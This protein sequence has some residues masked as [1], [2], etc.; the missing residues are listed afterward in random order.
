MTEFSREE[1]MRY[2][3]QMILPGFGKKKQ[4]LLKNARV[5]VVGAGGLGCP[6]LSYLGA[7]GVGT[8]GITDFDKIE[9]SNLHR[10]FLFGHEDVGKQKSTVATQKISAQ[11]Q[12]ITVI[13]HPFMLTDS[14]AESVIDEYDIVVDGSDNFLTRYMVNDTCLKLNKVLIYGS[15]LRGEGQVAVFN[16]RGSKNLRDLFHEAPDPE[17]VPSRRSRSSW[18]ARRNCRIDHGITYDQVHFR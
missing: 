10:Q 1:L 6:I 5:L 2:D 18:R 14:I 16:Y 17:D 11:N 7:A 15:I 12:F 8:I 3:R 13:D 4:S 9:T